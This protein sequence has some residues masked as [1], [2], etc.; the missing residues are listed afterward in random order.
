MVL[1]LKLLVFPPSLA[2]RFDMSVMFLEKRGSVS[3]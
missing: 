1:L 2:I 3:V